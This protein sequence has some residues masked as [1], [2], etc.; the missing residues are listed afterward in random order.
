MSYGAI[1]ARHIMKLNIPRLLMLIITITIL[2]ILA[3]LGVSKIQGKNLGSLY[4]LGAAAAKNNDWQKAFNHFDA[5]CKQNCQYQD[6]AT[7]LSEAARNAIQYQQKELT[8]EKEIKIIQWL[9]T[10]GDLDIATEALNHCTVVIPSGK[11]IMG[12]DNNDA[13]ERPQREIYLDTFEIDRYEVTNIQ[14][15]RFVLEMGYRTPHYWS[16]TNYPPGQADYPV[17]GVGWEDANAYCEWVGKRLPTEAEWEKACRGPDSNIYPWGDEWDDEK[18]NIGINQ[19][20]QWPYHYED[21]WEFVLTPGTSEQIL[22]LRPVGSYLDGASL[23]G[24]LDMIGNASEWIADW[25]NPNF[26]SEMPVENPVGLDPPWQHSVR[27]SAWYD[28]AGHESWMLHKSR[29][30]ARNASHSYDTPRLGFRCA[31]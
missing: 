8:I 4:A 24:V 21:G 12:E 16:G 29:C 11:F 27:G 5:L 1:I 2:A 9:V 15:Q 23:Y 3:V 7:R 13:D 26:Y 30:S 6:V 10:S 14:Y 25:Y 18:A 28:R 17:V 20:N 19:A 31:Q 22:G